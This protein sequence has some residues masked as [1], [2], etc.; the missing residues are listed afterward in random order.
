MKKKRINR[1][2]DSLK[3]ALEKIELMK[4]WY[5]KIYI[6]EHN[7]IRVNYGPQPRT[8]ILTIMLVKGNLYYYDDLDLES[9]DRRVTQSDLFHKIFPLFLSKVELEE[10]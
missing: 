4:G 7:T 5:F 1:V 10:L 8:H 3:R 6:P 2:I 9:G